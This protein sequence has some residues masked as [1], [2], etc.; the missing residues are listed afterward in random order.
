MTS[1]AFAFRPVLLRAFAR[2][3]TLALLL[4]I[5]AAC[6]DE[7]EAD[8]PTNTPRPPS[9]RTATA[10][11]RRTAA[12]AQ[13][14]VNNNAA[15]GNP[16]P[17]AE[18]TILIYLDGDNDLESSAVDDFREMASVGSTDQVNIVVEMDRIAS[19]EDWDD[20]SNGNWD[21]TKRF[22]ITKGMRPVER[23]QIADVG[24]KNMGDPKT[25]VD[26]VTWGT[27]TFPANRY[28]LIFWDHGAAW[29]GIAS[30]DSSDGDIITLP[31]LS[32]A[33][34]TIKDRSGVERFELLGFDACLMSQ[35]DVLEAIAPYGRVVVGSAELV[36]GE[37]W[38]WNSWLDDVT[39]NPQ[40]ASEAIAPV[41]IKTFNDFY[42]RQGETSV[43]LSAFDMDK[44]GAVQQSFNALSD[45]LLDDLKDSYK[46][47]GK[48]RAYAAEY[49]E[50]DDSIGAIDLGFFASSLVR[51]GASPRISAA[52]RELEQAIDDARIALAN[53][54][55]QPDATGLSVYFP[56]TR[57]LY[58][59]GYSDG[60]PMAESTSW[61]DFLDAFYR[62]GRTSG[63]R[64]AISEP[65]VSAPTAS[66]AE[67]VVLDATVSGEET[68]YVSYV[69]GEV[70]PNDNNT[71][72][73]ML[74]DYIY[75]PGAV[76]SDGAPEWPSGDSDVRLT[77]AATGWNL[78]NGTD[79]VRIPFSPL[80]YGSNIY[81]V[82]G[83]YTSA[84]T[85]DETEVSLE[86]EVVDG[87]GRLTN[88]WAFDEG[89]NGEPQPH[90]VTPVAGDTFTPSILTFTDTGGD[91]V[92][93]G[94]QP[95][96]P[97]T[98][99]AT[100]LL[101]F[102]APVPAGDYLVGL[103][104]EDLAGEISDQYQDITVENQGA[105]TLPADL[106]AAPIETQQQGGLKQYRSRKYG[107]T[108]SYPTTW[109]PASVGRGKVTFAERGLE[110]RPVFGVDVFEPGEQT[111]DARQALLDQLLADLSNED[112]FAQTD[113][114]APDA[115][116]GREALRVTFSYTDRDGDTINGVAYALTD[117]AS[118]RSYLLSWTVPSDL[119]DGAQPTL[120]AILA[121]FAVQ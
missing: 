57:K 107:Y 108:L 112:G 84:N 100:P 104:V 82:E 12:A 97:I 20:S 26:F 2:L 102:E 11:A 93:E 119:A 113:V 83:V 28:A 34:K 27:K 99:G 68:A 91:E 75:P 95:G 30:D 58:D 3:L 63:R 44:I 46:A 62:T 109:K 103:V 8:R 86:F 79:I 116:A 43:T 87:R 110:R 117:D 55:G 70:D 1:H 98:F 90:E 106:T 81:S 21:S 15:E 38:A 59:T 45:A 29:P 25:L 60:S 114:V 85:G 40:I 69:I 47:I 42:R 48:A 96:D 10:E 52:A 33:L 49:G 50:G 89:A 13:E 94:E 53:G 32:R 80:D 4:S 111:G 41:I 78:T 67:P 16:A 35:I 51:Q 7:P 6:A 39:R 115:V 66:N 74:L 88:V 24:E 23:S 54:E 18:W 17:T 61:D 105:V 118:G 14:Q 19:E 73:V 5:L 56:R 77:W 72:R 36:P 64:S 22:R 120:D 31:E 9:V 92:E 37:G 65:T 101:A 71:L 76:S 121:S